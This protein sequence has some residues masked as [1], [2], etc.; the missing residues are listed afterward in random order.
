MCTPNASSFQGLDHLNNISNT[1]VRM[2]K[3]PSAVTAVF[4]P[5][6]VIT[7]VGN[8]LVIITI[9][10]DPF[11]ELKGTANCLVLNL[12]V[13]D[14]LVGI[15]GE[16]LY[17]LRYW[18]PASG[19]TDAAYT[20]IYL[21]FIASFL[22]ILGLAVERLIVISS[23][24]SADYLTTTY[25]AIGILS[26][27]LFAGLI[28]F[29]IMPEEEYELFICDAIGIPII[30]LLFACYTRIY[31]LVKKSL[32]QGLSKGTEC[33]A[34]RQCLTVN[35]Q[36]IE[37]LKRRERS[38]AYSVFIL[39]GLFAVC[40]IPPFVLENVHEFCEDCISDKYSDVL[41]FIEASAIFL[42]PL[43]N[44]IAYS[45]RTVKFRKALRRIIFSRNGDGS[46]RRAIV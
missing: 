38:V 46:P 37:K 39:V 40:W 3:D 21:G 28:A 15:P 17:A 11:K 45:L 19:I 23:L 16:F 43:A 34:E 29:L 8:F 27:W 6:S 22:T 2:D 1:T 36:Y 32:R 4:L 20:T 7:A 25:R 13:C 5:L 41:S 10:K 44:P 31:F 24:N 9:L 42:H 30:I 12:A 14:L 18:V 33:A 35:G 26:I